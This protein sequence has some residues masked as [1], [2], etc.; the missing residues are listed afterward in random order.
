MYLYVFNVAL[1]LFLLL[2]L[3][4]SF[5]I[6]KRKCGKNKKSIWGYDQFHMETLY[7]QDSGGGS[8]VEIVVTT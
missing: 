2:C 4:F 5:I 7:E 3:Y 6:I 1:F 8:I